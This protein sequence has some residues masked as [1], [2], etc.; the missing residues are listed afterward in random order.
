M[1]SLAVFTKGFQA[2]RGSRAGTIA[3]RGLA[4]GTGAAAV[5]LGGSFALKQVGQATGQSLADVGAGAGRGLQDA[6][7][8]A[9]NGGWKLLPLAA[10]AVVAFWALTRRES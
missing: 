10:V 6:M 5:G 8:G 7:G 9:A 2:L 4:I 3:T 1:A